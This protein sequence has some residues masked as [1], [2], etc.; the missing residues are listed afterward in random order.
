MQ[1]MEYPLYDVLEH[2]AKITIMVEQ[3]LVNGIC[4]RGGSY[5]IIFFSNTITD[6]A[7][8]R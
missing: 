1:G 7:T 2:Y 5:G 3:E 8:L 6:N 4:G